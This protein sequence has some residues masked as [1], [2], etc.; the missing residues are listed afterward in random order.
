LIALRLHH[1]RE[2]HLVGTLLLPLA[3]PAVWGQMRSFTH[4]VGLDPFHGPIRTPDGSTPSAAGVPIILGHKFGPLRLDRV[5]RILRW[6]EGCGYSFSDLSRG[7]RTTGFPHIFTYDLRGRGSSASRLTITIRG[8]WT[9]RWM[10]AS[11][12]QL[13]LRWVLGHTM[14]TIRNRLFMIALH[15][16]RIAT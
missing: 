9:A 6:R 12:I 14:H 2:V 7:G 8:H 16:E 11:V 3:A 13:W 4:F 1:R 15:R 5:G 10:P